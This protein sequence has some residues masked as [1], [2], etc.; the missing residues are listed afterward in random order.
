MS[1]KL[2]VLLGAVQTV[3]LLALLIK[4]IGLERSIDVEAKAERPTV[5]EETTAN[6]DVHGQPVIST[7]S[8]SEKRLR[9]IV[10]EEVRSQFK[11]F[12]ASLTQ[13]A[14]IEESEPVSAAEYQYRLDAAMQQLDYYIGEKEISDIDMANLQGEIAGLDDEGRRQMLSLLTQALNSGELEG[15]F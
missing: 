8:L 13:P 10:R 7:Q 1:V 14:N 4:V 9:Q 15:R 12:G 6:D 2:I 3:L 5:M 11:E